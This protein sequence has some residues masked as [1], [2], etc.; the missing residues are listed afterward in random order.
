LILTRGMVARADGAARAESRAGPRGER[1]FLVLVAVPAVKALPD[2]GVIL[3]ARLAAQLQVGAGGEVI[4]RLEKAAMISKDA[5]LSGAEDESV[6]LRATVSEVVGDDDFG[7]FALTAS[8]DSALHGFRSSPRVAG[9]TGPGGPR[10]CGAWLRFCERDAGAV[11]FAVGYRAMPSLAT[12]SLEVRE[13]PKGGGFEL[14]SS[15]IFLDAPIV[16]AARKQ[17]TGILREGGHRQFH[18]AGRRF[19]DLFRQRTP[20]R[21]GSDTKAPATAV[22]DG[23]RARRPV[24]RLRA[25]GIVGR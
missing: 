14:R 24:E 25:G 10:Q 4:L 16:S 11:A 9:Q 12:A 23:H 2:D 8:Q 22:F 19:P 5:P 1:T 13:L 15:R 18:A 17:R 6:V 7:R 21:R 3:N 20:R